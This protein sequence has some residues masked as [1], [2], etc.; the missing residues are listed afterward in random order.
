MD[1]MYDGESNVSFC[2]ISEVERSMLLRVVGS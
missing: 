1:V 2:E